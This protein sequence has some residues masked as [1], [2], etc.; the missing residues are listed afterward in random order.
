MLKIQEFYPEDKMEHFPESSLP[1]YEITW[2][3]IPEDSN[4]QR[5][6]L[7]SLNIM[8]YLLLGSLLPWFNWQF[9]P[10]FYFNLF[11]H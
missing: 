6:N 9:T 7:C 1:I 8:L 10:F 3:Y 11:K 5:I 4:C 2:H